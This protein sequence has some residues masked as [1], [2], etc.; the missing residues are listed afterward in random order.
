MARRQEREIVSPFVLYVMRELKADTITELSRKSGI[1]RDTWRNW[2]Y[3]NRSPETALELVAHLE[4][5]TGMKAEELLVRFREE[6]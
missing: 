2:A 3:R 1:P 6:I 4:N 5:A